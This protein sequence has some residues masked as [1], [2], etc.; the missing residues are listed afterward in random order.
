MRK[1]GGAEGGLAREIFYVPQR[2]YVTLGTLSDQLVYPSTSSP[3]GSELLSP[4]RL[5]ELLALVDLEYLLERDGGPA[6]VVDWGAQL[7]LGEQQRLGMARL[8]FHR[9]KFAILDEC[10]SGVTVRKSLF[11]QCIPGILIPWATCATCKV[12]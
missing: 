6:A 2:P 3:S 10:T 11:E 9:P 1:P 5:R 12:K 7:S 8:F 4:A